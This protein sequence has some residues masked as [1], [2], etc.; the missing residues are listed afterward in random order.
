[1]QAIKGYEQ[2]AEAR[3]ARV[4]SQEAAVEQLQA[5]LTAKEQGEGAMKGWSKN[6]AMNQF[7]LILARMA[8]GEVGMRLVVWCTNHTAYALKI[9][10]SS[11][12][13]MRQACTT[14]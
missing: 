5:Q 11:S 1:M 9:A 4:A 8:R 7:K 10:A 3:I 6:K 12:L 13:Q 2:R 14:A